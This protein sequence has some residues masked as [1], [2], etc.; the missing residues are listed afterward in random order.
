MRGKVMI[1]GIVLGIGIGAA[2]GA[3]AGDMAHW[4]GLGVPLGV[5]IGFAMRGLTRR[6]RTEGACGHGRSGSCSSPT[7]RSA[8]SRE[9]DAR[10]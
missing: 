7:D 3:A 6:C 5:A 10:R 8:A 4:L 2:V 1:L 9:T